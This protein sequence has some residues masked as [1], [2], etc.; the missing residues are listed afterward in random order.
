MV[1]CFVL[2]FKC[3]ALSVF[4]ATPKKLRDITCKLVDRKGILTAKTFVSE[5]V[6]QEPEIICI[7]PE[8]K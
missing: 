4:T 2:F 3:I 6:D 8:N 5:K 7:C 1:L